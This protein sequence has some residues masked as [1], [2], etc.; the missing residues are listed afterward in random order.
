VGTDI[1]KWTI[2]IFFNFNLF[3]VRFIHRGYDLSDM[4]LVYTENKV[5][6]I[7]Y[8][9]RYNTINFRIQYFRNERFLQVKTYSYSYHNIHLMSRRSLCI[10]IF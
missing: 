2:S 4:E 1:C 9:V 7:I 8:D 10:K 5:T 3:C 6:N